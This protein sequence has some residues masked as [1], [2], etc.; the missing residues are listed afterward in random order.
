MTKLEFLKK[1]KADPVFRKRAISSLR[2]SGAASWI[3]GSVSP[4]ESGF[5]DR[6]RS[7]L[8]YENKNRY[9]LR[10]GNSRALARALEKSIEDVVEELKDAAWKHQSDLIDSAVVDAQKAWGYIEPLSAVFPARG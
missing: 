4:L 2:K 10:E 5:L 3:E 8:L 1:A 6:V 9:P 7:N